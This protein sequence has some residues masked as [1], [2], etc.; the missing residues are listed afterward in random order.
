MIPSI[1]LIHG[2]VPSAAV[3]I[4][5]SHGHGKSTPR[6]ISSLSPSRHSWT[7]G[8]N[9]H[10]TSTTN[11]NLDAS[12][13]TVFAANL[14]ALP[15]DEIR[16]AKSLYIRNAISD[17]RMS[18]KSAKGFLIVMGILSII[19]IFLIVSVP[20]FLGYRAGK[21]NGRQKIMNALDAWRADLGHDHDALLDLLDKH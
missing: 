9:K 17:Y 5:A 7:F 4:Q 14:A 3:W 6:L 18:I 8:Q 11:L 10:M 15:S 16:K 12:S 13:L 21:E 1:I 19:P 20:A 2:T